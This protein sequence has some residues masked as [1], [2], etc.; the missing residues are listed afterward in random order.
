[1]FLV[2]VTMNRGRGSSSVC[3]LGAVREAVIC[4]TLMTL[5]PMSSRLLDISSAGCQGKVTDYCL[6]TLFGI[7]GEG[8]IVEII[9][10]QVG[11]HG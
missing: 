10:V 2:K 1:M 3:P 9:F 11:F 4:L 6:Y 7:W 5:K 8:R